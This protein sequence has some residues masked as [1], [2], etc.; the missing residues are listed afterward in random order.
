MSTII[1][2][3]RQELISNSSEALKKSSQHFFKEGVSCYG[4]KN[5]AVVEIGK[6]CFKTIKELPKAEIF[7]LCD[8]LWQSGYLEE[9]IIACHWSFS[10]SKQFAPDDIKVFQ[11]WINDHV[12][13]WASCDTFCNQTVGKFVEIYPEY[14][15]ELKRWTQS[16][17]RWMRRAAAVSLIVPARRGKFLTDIFEIADL[18]LTDQDDMVQKGY[19]WML[20]VASQTHQNEVFDYVFSKR[21]VMPRTALRYAIEKMPKELKTKAMGK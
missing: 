3:L 10:V 9:S 15:T 1:E 13:N 5:A 7:K 19:G 12:N 16:E 11:R 2:N 14:L 18:L 20:K 4:L 17:N 21:D 6:A 8:E